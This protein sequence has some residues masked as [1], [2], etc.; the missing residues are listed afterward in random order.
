MCHGS[1]DAPFKQ[2]CFPQYA[3]PD[4]LER[5]A[6]VADALSLGGKTKEEK[7]R[8]KER[9]Y[10]IRVGAN[11]VCPI[12][13]CS[14]VGR[15]CNQRDGHVMGCTFGG[16]CSRSCC[17]PCCWLQVIKL[18]EAIEKL[19]A[20]V[21]CPATIKDVIGKAPE[22]E[23]FYMSTSEQILELLLLLIWSISPGGQSEQVHNRL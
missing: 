4:A 23:W 2:T 8:G 6:E 11:R 3:V 5:Y 10:E 16:L 17:H 9:T 21:G 15:G 18:I 13:S 22:A 19:K 12:A 14:M 1:A 20:D 7:V